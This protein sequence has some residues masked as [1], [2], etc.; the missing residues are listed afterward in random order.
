MKKKNALSLTSSQ[1]ILWGL[2]LVI[3]AAFGG[4]SYREIKS[5]DQSGR[6]KLLQ[7]INEISD[8]Q[9][10]AK[11]NLEWVVANIGL[12]PEEQLK[13]S[14]I[15]TAVTGTV[16]SSSQEPGSLPISAKHY[17]VGE[18]GYYDYTGKIVLAGLS[19]ETKTYYFS[20][21]RMETMEVYVVENGRQVPA[22]FEEIATEDRVEIEETVDLAQSN[23][24]D[25]NLI[26]LTVLI[27]R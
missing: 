2:V 17:Y 26:S 24:D 18:P 15:A 7:A 10:F 20:P 16:V 12:I 22:T 6:A 9:G 5:S 4:Y 21:R 23:I 11:S 13:H 27:Y 14:I 1:L 25:D 19:G 3:L 8:N